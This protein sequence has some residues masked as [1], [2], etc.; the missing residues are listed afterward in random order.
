MKDKPD[1]EEIRGL[2]PT[3]AVGQSGVQSNPRSTVGTYTGIY[4]LY[5]LLFSRVG[6]GKGERPLSTQFSFN[7]IQGA[8]REC[9]GLGMLTLCDPEKLITNPERSILQGAMDG[10]KTGKFY[11]DP[12]GQYVAPLKAVGEKHSIDY[13]ICWNELSQEGKQLAFHGCGEETYDVNWEFLRKKRSGTHHFKGRWQG[14]LHLVNEEYARKHADHR[15]NSMMN[16][17]SRMECPACHGSRLNAEALSWVIH[18]KNIRDISELSITDS[19]V[20]FGQPEKSVKPGISSPLIT[21]ILRRLN[22]LETLGLSY[23]TISRSVG[24]LSHGEVR[25]LQL[26]A[27]TGSGLSGMIYI[28]DEPTAGLHSR[29][30]AK[31]LEHIRVLISSGNTV[32]TVEHERELILGADHIIDMGPGAGSMGGKIVAEGSPDEIMNS[33]NSITGKYLNTPFRKQQQSARQLKPCLHIRNAFIHNLK[34]INIEIPSGGIT[35]ITGVSGSGKSSLVFDL[36]YDSW[37]EGKSVGCSEISGFGNFSRIV[38]IEQREEFNSPLAVVATYS[39][40]FDLIRIQFAATEDA[41]KRGF[42]KNHFS[43]LNKQS[44][45]P[46]CEGMG[47]TRISMDF[48]P[49]IYRECEVCLGKRYSPGILEVKWK[50]KSIAEI[51]ELSV[52]EASA[53]FNGNKSLHSILVNLELAGLGYLT[54][55][56]PLNTLSG[57]EGQRLN[58]CKELLKLPQSLSSFVNRKSSPI[59]T[60]PSLYLFDEPST[61]LHFRDI[62]NLLKLFNTLADQGNTLVIIEHD[63]QIIAEADFIIELGPGGGDRGGYLIPTVS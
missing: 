52:S 63:Q 58:L 24:S 61:G 5:R 20:F 43:F 51:L 13:N 59:N 19:I 39:G 32:I 50:G 37:H 11:G 62:E 45:C 18:Q 48:M 35:C 34:N 16:A 46:H 2:R 36:I 1:F 10:S 53:F 38:T 47:K 41:K 17:M 9:D 42:S 21:E 15:G 33:E 23:L 56:Q 26:A 49:D 3:F 30:T 40:A 7:S 22:T 28:L 8:C 29:D 6:E 14:L 12:F 31:L 4:D 25:R 54:L 55:G 27:Q 57:G 60:T 44:Q